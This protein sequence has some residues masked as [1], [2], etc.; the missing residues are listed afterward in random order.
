[1]LLEEL[2]RLRRTIESEYENDPKK[3]LEHLLSIQRQ[4]EKK[5]VRRMPEKALTQKHAI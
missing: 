4:Y 2:R 3:Y 1:M 5:L